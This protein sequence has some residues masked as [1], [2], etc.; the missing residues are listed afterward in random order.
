MFFSHVCKQVIAALASYGAV[1]ALMVL[2]ASDEM[3]PLDVTAQRCF[4]RGT[5]EIR[6]AF[7][8]IWRLHTTL[9]LQF[10]CRADRPERGQDLDVDEGFLRQERRWKRRR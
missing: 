4:T 6:A 1:W 5:F 2:L 10:P 8:A 7:A 9:D 3:V